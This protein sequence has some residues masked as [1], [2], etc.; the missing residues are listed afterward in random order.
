MEERNTGT[1]RTVDSL[2]L[3]EYF[4]MEAYVVRKAGAKLEQE[5]VSTSSLAAPPRRRESDRQGWATGRA[6]PQTV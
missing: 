4:A 6:A 1:A 2:G 5:T 3:P